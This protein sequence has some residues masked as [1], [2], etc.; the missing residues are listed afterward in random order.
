MLRWFDKKKDILEFL[1]KD[2][3]N[4]RY[5]ARQ[6]EKWWIMCENW[7]YC[8]TSDYD[9]YYF[10]EKIKELEDKLEKV[11]KEMN[12]YKKMVDGCLDILL[13]FD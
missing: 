6:L 1:G 3:K 11:E 12:K 10:E 2:W 8:F 7:R 13:P 9:R 4:V 5:L